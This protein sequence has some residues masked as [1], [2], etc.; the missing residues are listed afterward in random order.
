[1]E[2]SEKDLLVIILKVLNE[3]NSK[4]QDL[5]NQLYVEPTIENYDDMVTPISKEVFDEIVKATGTKLI[6][7]GIA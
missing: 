2:K 6:F 3:C 7:M 5:E 4:L 1:M